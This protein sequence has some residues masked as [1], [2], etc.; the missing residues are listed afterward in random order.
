[1]SNKTI[2]CV[3]DEQDIIELLSV[4]LR[5]EGY[6]IYT[7][8]DGEE[9]LTIAQQVEPDMF[10]LDVM[11]PEK[12][13]FELCKELRMDERFKTSAIFFLTAKDDEID[14]V[15]GLE[16]GAD[17]YIRKPFSPRTILAKIK[18]VF[19]RFERSST[20]D[21]ASKE[22][23][24]FHNLI[25]DRLSY[26]VSID[27]DEVKFLHK[28]F[29]LLHFLMTHTSRVFSRRELLNYVWG[30]DAYFVERT[31]DV[32]ITKIRKKLGDYA[33]HI[34]TVSGVGYKFSA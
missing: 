25:V 4:T 11:M 2:L 27:Q 5:K 22:I 23:V 32:H 8:K 1:M 12:D 16:Y 31:V 20:L 14:E 6:T 29:E 21:N 13:G 9:A 7:A 19:R 33:K 10:I 26:S 34:Q 17:D 18:A 30:E 15:L 28:E 24:K 3:D